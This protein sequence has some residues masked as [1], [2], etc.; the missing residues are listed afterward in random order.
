VLGAFAIDLVGAGGLFLYTA[1]A[2]AGFVLFTVYRMTRRAAVPPE[3]RATDT[4]AGR[5]APAT[6]IALELDPRAPEPLEEV[7]DEPRAA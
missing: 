3:D 4:A 7:A 6:P 2:H 1:L 5:P